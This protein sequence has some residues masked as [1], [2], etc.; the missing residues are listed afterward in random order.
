[1]AVVRRVADVFSNRSWCHRSLLNAVV[2]DKVP[3]VVNKVSKPSCGVRVVQPVR[4]NA[5]THAFVGEIG[6]AVRLA[7]G[8][9]ASSENFF[10]TSVADAD[11]ET[12][13]VSIAK[14]VSVTDDEYSLCVV[15]SLLGSDQISCAT[16]PGTRSAAFKRVNWLAARRSSRASSQWSENSLSH[17]F[18]ER[19]RKNQFVSATRQFLCSSC[20]VKTVTGV[21]ILSQNW[22]AIGCILSR[23]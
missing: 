10:Q 18:R 1:L 16:E 15:E 8:A 17:L 5:T 7:Q 9:R 12:S 2:R 14:R 20:R 13:T 11:F 4:R 3:D 6:A 22:W 19:H 23:Q 21:G